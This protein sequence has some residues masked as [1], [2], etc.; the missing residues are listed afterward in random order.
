MA[1]PISRL[2]EG[3]YFGTVLLLSDQ[4]NQSN[5]TNNFSLKFPGWAAVFILKYG[6][7]ISLP[8]LQVQW[9][10]SVGVFTF[11]IHGLA[12]ICSLESVFF[13]FCRFLIPHREWLGNT[14]IS[15]RWMFPFL[16]LPSQEEPEGKEKELQAP[17]QMSWFGDCVWM[18]NSRCLGSPESFPSKLR[19]CVEAVPGSSACR[20]AHCNGAVLSCRW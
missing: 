19:E 18:L 17:G 2:F 9:Q 13:C 8:N 10:S 14:K 15:G 5:N 4:E 1:I 20:M 16:Y 12:A 6:K 3:K 11:Q 7:N